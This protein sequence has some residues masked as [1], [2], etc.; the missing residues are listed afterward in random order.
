MTP[1]PVTGTYTNANSLF[2]G[3]L[4]ASGGVDAAYTGP[5]AI[6]EQSLHIEYYRQPNTFNPQL[7]TGWEDHTLSTTNSFWEEELNG[8]RMHYRVTAFVRKYKDYNTYDTSTYTRN[9][10]FTVVPTVSDIH[11][12]TY[13]DLSAGPD[14]V[15][16][17]QGNIVTEQTY[18][19]RTAWSDD[20]DTEY[21][22]DTSDGAFNVAFYYGTWG[23]GTSSVPATDYWTDIPQNTNAHALMTGAGQQYHKKLLQPDYS[24]PSGYSTDKETNTLVKQF[25]DQVGARLRIGYYGLEPDTNEYWPLATIKIEDYNESYHDWT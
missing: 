6:V 16:G 18:Y 4:P 25:V 14:L 2:S 5:W 8:T 15:L 20:T 23:L 10:K 3:S 13:G 17:P 11:G 24:I 1:V 19:R 12:Y 9:Q 7:K 22:Y 21:N